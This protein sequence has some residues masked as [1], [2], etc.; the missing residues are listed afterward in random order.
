MAKK[1]LKISKVIERLEQIK[2]MAGDLEIV[3]DLD[4]NGFYNLEKVETRKTDD[5]EL[6]CNF[7]SSNEM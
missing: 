6:V 3:I 4:E 7:Q 5:G 2:D 1:P